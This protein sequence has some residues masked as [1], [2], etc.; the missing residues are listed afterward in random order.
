MMNDPNKNFLNLLEKVEELSSKRKQIL[1]RHFYELTKYNIDDL[2]DRDS[3]ITRI[4]GK[5]PSHPNA[6]LASSLGF[7]KSSWNK[8]YENM[9]LKFGLDRKLKHSTYRNM[10]HFEKLK[11]LVIKYH[12]V[13][14]K[15]M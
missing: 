11:L 5:A 3:I 6:F 9:F 14:K 10:L 12:E 1:E 2:E 15:G 8:K 7:T 13:N 4:V